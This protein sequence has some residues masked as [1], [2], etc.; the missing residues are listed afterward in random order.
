MLSPGHKVIWH[1]L[2]GCYNYERIC[3]AQGGERSLSSPRGWERNGLDLS[4]SLVLILATTEPRTY[5]LDRSH[6]PV[7][8]AP[9]AGLTPDM[10]KRFESQEPPNRVTP[11]AHPAQ[12]LS[13]K[14]GTGRL[15]WSELSHLLVKS[16]YFIKKDRGKQLSTMNSQQSRISNPQSP[17]SGLICYLSCHPL[18]VGVA[19]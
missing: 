1:P 14:V 8:S 5:F 2:D 7:L 10:W 9:C 12:P 19:V 13:Q 15:R 17:A 3:V 18:K 16:P 11:M 4:Y 6:C